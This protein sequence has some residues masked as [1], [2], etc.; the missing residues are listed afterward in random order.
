MYYCAATTT[1]KALKQQN[2]EPLR[3]RDVSPSRAQR[4]QL[5]RQI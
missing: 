4:L 3:S 1:G 5:N 2:L